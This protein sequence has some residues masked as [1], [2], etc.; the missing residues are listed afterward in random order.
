MDKKVDNHTRSLLDHQAQVSSQVTF[1][2]H[3]D[4]TMTVQD[5]AK[6]Q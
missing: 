3:G 1:N 2:R 6:L 4:K 5:F